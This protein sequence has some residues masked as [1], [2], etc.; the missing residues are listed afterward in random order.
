MDNVIVEVVSDE[1]FPATIEGNTSTDLMKRG[2]TVVSQCEQLLKQIDTSIE[3]CRKNAEKATASANTA[4]NVK[5]GIFRK[6]ASIEALQSAMVDCAT[7]L[8]AQASA[9]T[10][11]S[12]HQRK[13][14][15]SQRGLYHLGALSIAA[16][17]TVLRE[18]KARLNN[19]SQNELDELAQ[20]ELANLIEELKERQDL[21]MKLESLERHRNNIILEVESLGE[22]IGA[23]EEQSRKLEGVLSTHDSELKQLE[24][25]DS[26]LEEKITLQETE[27][28]ALKSINNTLQQELA[29]RKDVDA[30]IT[31]MQRVFRLSVI[32]GGSLVALLL[33]GL[34]VVLVAVFFR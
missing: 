26:T 13:I 4:K 17:R 25:T 33:A 32:I 11:L 24:K 19:A 3:Q 5:V 28:E 14:L 22:R 34:V 9:V 18:L 8:E 16:N 30:S 10:M 6:A 2:G 27:F 20:K 31:K 1:E 7:G 21:L 23:L 12:M 15:D 29:S